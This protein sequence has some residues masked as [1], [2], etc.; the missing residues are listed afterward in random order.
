MLVPMT[1]RETL[2]VATRAA[3]SLEP[4]S[5]FV[6]TVLSPATPPPPVSLSLPVS[7][8]PAVALPARRTMRAWAT[9]VASAM[10]TVALVAATTRATVGHRGSPPE[11]APA[12]TEAALALAPLPLV[13]A[14]A[15]IRELA[16]SE[17][18][19]GRPA[20]PA[21]VS[22]PPPTAPRQTS[23]RARGALTAAPKPPEP[24]ERRRGVARS[25]LPELLDELPVGDQTLAEQDREQR[26]HHRLP[27]R[28]LPEHLRRVRAV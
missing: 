2:Q 25:D 28:V 27:L 3:A 23:P 11:R 4:S 14:S 13:T 18:P 15:P 17:E 16:R 21:A 6:A 10:A 9:I 8:A 22:P 12:T 26:R 19:T 7:A 20:D 5:P 24:P 1:E